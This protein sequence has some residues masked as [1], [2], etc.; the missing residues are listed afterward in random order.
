MDSMN[1]ALQSGYRVVAA[2]VG[3]HHVF[4]SARFG[5]TACHGKHYAVAERDDGRFHVFVIVIPFGNL[6]GT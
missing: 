2:V 4:K 3:Y 1:A 5:K 6:F